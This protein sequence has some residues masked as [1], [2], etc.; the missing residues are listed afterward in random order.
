MAY[1][2][3][4]FWMWNSDVKYNSTSYVPSKVYDSNLLT[5]WK[6]LS[7]AA[8]GDNSSNKNQVSYAYIRIGYYWDSIDKVN[9]TAKIHTRLELVEFQNYVC[10]NN[11]SLLQFGMNIVGHTTMNKTKIKGIIEYKPYLM[12]VSG[13]TYANRGSSFRDNYIVYSSNGN[14]FPL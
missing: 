8:L 5:N 9:R 1:N 6:Y 13:Y 3:K 7:T 14:P 12:N 11:Q 10:I 2:S 4:W